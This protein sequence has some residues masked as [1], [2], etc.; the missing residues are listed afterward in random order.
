MRPLLEWSFANQPT[1]SSARDHI[2]GDDAEDSF[3]DDNLGL[4]PF[5]FS[6]VE[7]YAWALISRSIS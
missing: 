2:G 1:L 7:L 3:K 5:D 4:G 6:A